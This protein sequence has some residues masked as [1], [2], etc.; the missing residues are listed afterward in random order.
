MQPS[1]TDLFADQQTGPQDVLPFGLQQ[2]PPADFIERIRAELDA[3]LQKVREAELLPWP[4]LTHT[5]MAELRFHSIAAWLPQA[6]ATL[7]RTSF[8]EEMARLYA[9]EDKRFAAAQIKLQLEP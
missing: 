5:T 3:T 6:E 9:E 1:Q 7:L 8:E 2:P 4:D